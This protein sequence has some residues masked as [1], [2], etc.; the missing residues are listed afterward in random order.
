MLVYK[1][2]KKRK[3]E[4]IRTYRKTMEMKQP[5][6]WQHH[7]TTIY[8]SNHLKRQLDDFLKK[9]PCIIYVTKC[10]AREFQKLAIEQNKKYQCL[11]TE[12]H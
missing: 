9:H 3:K 12:I 2:K 6:E 10:L 11:K 8:F 1:N 7:M 4:K 5:K